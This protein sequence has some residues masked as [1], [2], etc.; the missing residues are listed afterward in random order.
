MKI[1]P[2]NLRVH[3]QVKNKMT[4]SQVN[5]KVKHITSPASIMESY[6][7]HEMM[8]ESMWKVEHTPQALR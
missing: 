3:Q 6:P 8:M 7:R 1:K 5:L 4:R 2:F